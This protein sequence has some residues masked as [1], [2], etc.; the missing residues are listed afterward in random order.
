[1]NA[2]YMRVAEK[3]KDCCSRLWQ[4]NLLAA[5]DGNISVRLENDEIM[6]T[7]SG[8]AKAFMRPEECCLIKL[9]GTVLKG[10]PSSE[11]QMHLQVYRRCPEARSVVHAHPPHA[12][13]WSV[14][15]PEFKE[16]PAESLSEVILAAGCI[17][18]VA[19]ARPT[20]KDMADAIDAYLPEHRLMILARHG[21]LA[22]GDSLEEAT[23][24][25]ERLEHSAQILYLS[26]QLG[27]LTKLPSE[28][29]EVLRSMRKQ[30]GAQ[31]L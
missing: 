23:N 12:I 11:R 18:I 26:Q 22:W 30:M 17:P 2:D 4:R 3:I 7:P 6:M 25:M 5:A 13:A 14:A 28:E 9:D 27:G 8:L 16:L 31:L 15:H 29:I 19:Y 20:Q 24:G 1:M 21:G 10:K